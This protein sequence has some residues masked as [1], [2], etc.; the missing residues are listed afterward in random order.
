MTTR[1]ELDLAIDAIAAS[2]TGALEIDD[3]ES[4]ALPNKRAVISA[5]ENLAPA[6][7]LG[8]YATHPLY[9]TNL[10][11][12][13]AEQVE[14]VHKILVEQIGR[15]MRYE[16]QAGRRPGP[17]DGYGERV[18]LELLNAIP[19]LRAQLN[20]DVMAAYH[21]DPA[22]H[23]VEEIVFSYPSIVALTA[24]RV[25]HLLHR[26]GV[27]LIPRIL[28]EHASSRTGI[29]INPEAQIGERFFIDHGKGVVIGAT[30]IIG[31]GVK[32]Y[33]N[34]TLGA[35]SVRDRHSTPK[36]RHP[37]IEDNVTIYSGAT[38]LGG[39][40]VIGRGSVIG[41]NVW[42]TRSVPPDSRIFGRSKSDSE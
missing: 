34:V 4:V 5:L 28:T 29:D 25:A 8:F 24:Y 39:E 41:G 37:T 35:L 20:G 22:A 14:Y 17:T 12:E 26:A 11:H 13:I 33:Q 36:K 27:P 38:I 30:A 10:R 6:L 19:K 23:S 42:L 1:S 32:I 16:V 9:R 3:L 18:A 2:Y 21:G 40:T 15:A 31:D 7:F